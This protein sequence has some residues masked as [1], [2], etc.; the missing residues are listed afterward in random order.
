VLASSGDHAEQRHLAGLLRDLAH[1]L[2]SEG[3]DVPLQL[4][5]VKPATSAAALER[6]A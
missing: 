5:V 3:I 4:R 2:E 1:E 6:V